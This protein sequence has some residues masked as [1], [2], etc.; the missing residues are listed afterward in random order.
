MDIPVYGVTF[1]CIIYSIMLL[2]FS[3]LDIALLK[4]AI[5]IYFPFMIIL[6]SLF[7]VSRSTSLFI[8]QCLAVDTSYFGSEPNII[9]LKVF[10]VHFRRNLCDRIYRP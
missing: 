2:M 4:C 8:N 3:V 7:S 9:V 1:Y 6:L 10:S 5:Q